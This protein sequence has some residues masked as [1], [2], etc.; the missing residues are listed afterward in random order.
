MK[1][2]G[3]ETINQDGET[4]KSFKTK[5]TEEVI[6]RQKIFQ[7]SDLSVRLFILQRFPEHILQDLI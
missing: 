6:E 4:R 2:E 5:V 1:V 7:W 3:R